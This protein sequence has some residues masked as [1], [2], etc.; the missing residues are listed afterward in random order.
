MEDPKAKKSGKQGVGAPAKGDSSAGS[1]PPVDPIEGATMADTPA[2]P[3]T[4]PKPTTRV[5]N[6]DATISDSVAGMSMSS[7][8]RWLSGVYRQEAILQPGDLIGA[9]YE[10]VQLLGEGGM[11]AVYKATDHEVERTVALKVIRPE[12]T[13]NP[14]ILARFKQELLTAHQVTHRNV[15]RIYDIAEADGVKFI[16]MEF[17]EGQDLRHIL[18]EKGKLAVEQAVEIIRQVCFALDA[19]HSVGIIHRDLKP[20][21]IMQETK[22]GRIL[23]MDFGLARSIGGDGMTQTGA[24]LG[25]IEYMSPE[26]SMGQPLDQRSDIFALGLIF[27][28]LLVG[29]TP[30]KADSA[31]ASLLKRNQE[32]AVPAAELDSSVPKALSDI[33]AKCLERELEHRY[34][35]VQEI[36]H[37][38]DAF[39]GARPTL[40]SISLPGIVQ[41]KKQP[42][43]K[44]IAVG[45]L[46]V[47]LIGGGWVL[48]SVVVRSNT[49]SGASAVKG[50]ELSLAIL[51]FRNASGDAS[52]DWLG[53]TLADMLSTG[54][55]QSSQMR[56]VPPDA[57]HQTL[58]D[59][60]ITP[61][62][63]MDPTM[64][65]HI[66][67]SSKANTI[68]WGKYMRIG[69]GKV[70][71]DATLTDLKHDK[72]TSINIDASSQ[73]L[74]ATAK[75]IADQI[76]QHL[77]VSANVLNELK[78]SSFQPSSNSSEALRDYTQA[79]QALRE[80]RNLDATK[81]LEAAIKEDPNFALAYARLAEANAALGYDVDAEKNS[82]KAVD[83]SQSLPQGERYFIEADHLRVVKDGKKAI[84]AYENLAK[85]LPS[86]ADVEYALGDLYSSD[87]QYEKARTQFAAM[88]KADPNSIKA[89]W[90]LGNL[91]YQQENY[92]AALEP[93]NKALSLAVQVGNEEQKAV[94]L[95]SLGIC[96][97]LMNKPADA[98]K[99]VQDSME[100]TRR[101]GMK[102]QLA[103][104][105][106]E[107]AISEVTIG[108][109]D[110]ALASDNQALQ[111]LREIG[112]KKDYGDILIN[113]GLHY[114]MRGE[115][116]KA[117]QDYKD[118]LQIQRDAGDLNYQALCLN[119][120]GYV[121][122][123]KNDTDNALIYYQQSLE[124]RQKVNEPVY[125]AQTLSGLGDVYTAMGEYD[126]ALDS[127]MKAL[128]NSRKA[129]DPSS[130]ASAAQSIG[131]ILTYQGRLGAALSA[132]Q[133]AVKGYRS[134]NNKGIEL[135]YALNDL[136][137][138]LIL[139][140]RG[141]DSGK[142][143]EEATQ[144]AS[145]LR[146]ET[147]GGELL[148]T[149]GDAAFYRA[150]Y[151]DA[152]SAYEQAA[153]AA[154]KT[155][156]RQ[157][158]A[159]S[160][161]NLGRISIAEG[162]AKAAI[163]ELRAATQQM[164]TLGLKYAWLCGSVDL[165][166][167]MIKSK[168]YDGARRQ[169]DQALN[170]SEKLGTRQLTAMIHFQSGNLLKL[171]NDA[172]GAADQYR[173][174]VALLD[175]MKREQGAEH[176]LERADLKAIYTESAEGAGQA[177]SR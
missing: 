139:V 89:L 143:L 106:A 123:E 144:I 37:D 34:Q 90:E 11:G 76:R 128:E 160:K 136:A 51:P 138:T 91:E 151:K 59:L 21:N 84:A 82:R 73:D 163:S 168:D 50:P 57:L 29:K 68:L 158:V 32:R 114:A 104:S 156:D 70:R 41:P 103:N 69:E 124:L 95:H 23:V 141:N 72:T 133:D 165:A 100:I 121:Y 101:L 53:P 14:A 4:P 5:A 28:E 177:K 56:V 35:N 140:G 122:Y 3:A 135:A 10:I 131:K 130:A 48:K 171:T 9:R 44:W 86:N 92:Q 78:A 20:Q 129:N 26:Q 166:E 117:L 61:D 46:T 52:I 167:A 112:V 174:V 17:V 80:G 146:N 22:T 30:Y 134:A 118:A 85:I 66:A 137:G 54:V 47:A 39:Q 96:Y 6:P 55:G 170:T 81:G 74:A 87:G 155:K 115:F 8:G 125:L 63:S 62:T 65:N 93:L 19:A 43:W 153:Q 161:M 99:S 38:L 119:N 18:V 98:I 176:I 162:Q 24:L 105:L 12:L 58:S 173:Q 36:L 60:R 159:I 88:L 145:D 154:G 16:T 157:E 107:L 49:G 102:R 40:A 94:I 67:E 45:T 113:R 108:K 111:I 109:S 132:M 1:T 42:P 33:V 31:M 27:Y 2:P 142:P 127:Q 25:T 110:A 148:S 79:V 83:L 126:K 169:L 97:R 7:A 71:I 77:S 152:R 172:S 164:E 147:I 75:Q 149:K 150:D 64:V 15:I 120:I 116:D 175:E 13:S